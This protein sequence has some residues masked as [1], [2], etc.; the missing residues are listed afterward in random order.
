MPT[1]KVF[2]KEG[3]EVGDIQ[4]NE[5]IFDVEISKEA[6]HQVVLAQLANKRQGTQSA[7]TR[8]EVRGGG[9]KPWRQ[10]GTG[11][12]RQGSIRAPQWIHGGIVFAPKPRNYRVSIPKS[13]RRAAMKSALTSKVTE[14]EMI[15]L[16]SLNFE[17]PKTKEMIKVLNAFEA[18]K[19]LIVVAESNDNVYKSARN[20][21]GV[22]VLPVNNLNVYDILKY[23]K[24]MVTK[25][26]VSKIEEVYA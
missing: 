1:V 11:R 20:I 18:K 14:N 9:I 8:A 24:F 26:A 19:T 4:L 17:A 15:V 2:N 6:M 5:N 13:M 3:K 25:E 16:E 21:P 22:A 12:A 7:K 23:E 10:K